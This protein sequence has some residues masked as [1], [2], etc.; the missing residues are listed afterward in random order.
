MYLKNICVIFIIMKQRLFLTLFSLLILLPFH[1]YAQDKVKNLDIDSLRQKITV[2]SKEKD[3]A[4]EL[5]MTYRAAGH[6]HLQIREKRN[7]IPFFEKGLK[8]AKELEA[9]KEIYYFL[10]IKL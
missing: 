10:Y 9:E 4:E 2:L 1:F 7:A 8:L 3:K 5:M 6:Y